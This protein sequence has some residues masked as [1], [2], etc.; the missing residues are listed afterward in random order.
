M[1][2]YMY[3]YTNTCLETMVKSYNMYK[4]SGLLGVVP[5]SWYQKI[6]SFYG[7][8]SWIKRQLTW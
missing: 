4:F 2:A 7:N 6:A 3:T 5:Q 8:N 1:T